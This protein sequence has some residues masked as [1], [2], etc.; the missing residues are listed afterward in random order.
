MAVK[1]IDWA[2]VPKVLLDAV[3][4]LVFG[5]PAMVASYIWQAMSAG[6]AFGE[7]AFSPDSFHSRYGGKAKTDELLGNLRDTFKR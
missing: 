4:L 6:W 5:T 7:W 1:K 3:M 2:E